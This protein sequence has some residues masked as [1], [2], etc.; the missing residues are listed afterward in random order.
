MLLM[1]RQSR[2]TKKDLEGVGLKMIDEDRGAAV[3]T[4]EDSLEVNIGM[5]SR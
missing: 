4:E 5:S 1:G 2:P 3:V